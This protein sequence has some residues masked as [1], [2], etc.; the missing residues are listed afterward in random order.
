M[1]SRPGDW[2]VWE[3][4]LVDVF[5]LGIRLIA[6]DNIT[7][8]KVSTYLR[9]ASFT[10]TRMSGEKAEILETKGSVCNHSTILR[11]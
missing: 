5:I 8:F 3:W 11:G 9:V 7:F 4:L 2:Q 6:R 10:G 1:L